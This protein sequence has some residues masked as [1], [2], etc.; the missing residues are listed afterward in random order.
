MSLSETPSGG[1]AHGA[2]PPSHAEPV[3][4][5]GG[6]PANDEID[7]RT[8]VRVLREEWVLIAGVFA[9]IVLLA[10]LYTFTRE[11]VYE[12][13]SVVLVDTQRGG[14]RLAQGGIED[15]L[16]LSGGN[17]TLENEVAVL[18]QSVPLA[19]RVAGRLLD[20]GRQ[21]PLT[22]A[23]DEGPPPAVGRVARTMLKD[24]VRFGPISDRADLIRVVASST[25]PE[26]AALLA[27][28]YAEEYTRRSQ[29]SSRASVASS[30]IFLEDQERKR[31]EELDEAEGQ[32]QQFMTREGAVAL[33]SEGQRAV[34]QLAQLDS[35]I[36][37]AQVELE[38][39][40]TALRS[41]EA[42]VERIQPGLSRRLASG[43]EAEMRRV[44]EQIAELEI[45]ASDYYA[46]NP[47]LRG[48][49][50]ANAELLALS[51]RITGLRQRLDDLS[52]RY[53]QEV[54]AVGGVDGASGT[55]TGL[56]YLTELQ[57][58]AIQRR[59]RIQGLEAKVRALRQQVGQYEVRLRDIPRQ[60]IQLAQLQRQQQAITDTYLFLVQKLQEARVAEE[61][62][63]GY[64][65]IIR[66][67]DVPERPVRPRPLLN[68][69]VA[70]MLGLMGG[71]GAALLRR[72]LDHRVRS[73]EDLREN[74]FSVLGT[75]PD[76]T[77]LI[78][79]HF[80]G[81]EKV[82]IVNREVYA[83][84]AAALHPRSPLTEA[85]RQ[86]RTSVRFSLPDTELK[87]VSVTSTAP[88]E[89]KSTTSLQ[90]ALSMASAG[91]RTLYI[92]G[93][94]RK[95]TGH[96]HLG[97]DRKRGLSELLFQA[98]PVDWE[99]YR[100]RLVADWADFEETVEDLYVITAGKPVPSPSELLGSN[101]MRDLVTEMRREFDFVVIDTPPTLL[102]TD[103]VLAAY[104]S[105][106]VVL[107][108]RAEQTNWDALHRTRETV[109]QAGTP[110]IG[111]VL[112]RFG[113]RA[114]GGY[115]YGYG[116]Y[117][118]G[119]GADFTFALSGD[120]SSRPTVPVPSVESHA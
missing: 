59:I 111:V 97:L 2:R 62:E 95:P 120:G 88:G 99:S 85:A 56:P 15:L 34:T 108:A 46:V 18:Q 29:E 25:D 38:I 1:A 75:F 63:L 52:G 28:L 17:R 78:K 107:V 65:Q 91:L 24:H 54:L 53:L 47:S 41:L 74:G 109:A 44:Q 61:S 33:D 118:Y 58:D 14:A 87:V 57:R 116:S 7:L 71:V 60:S 23:S 6:A 35:Q 13:D 37:E 27:N 73:P 84:I 40:R 48:N 96:L 45:Q 8:L 43:I 102:V 32:L 100:C 110:V 39:E 86:L 5:P 93:D 105:D 98:G 49:E 64:I 3:G 90:L 11:P 104:L 72:A 68:L 92:D 66:R 82:Q 70:V 19:E 113:R 36:E 21:G 94:L 77:A 117:G 31:R 80:G 101:R 112:N 51:T 20:T 9:A 83:T 12:T 79:E 103:A 16:R 50:A 30:R 22:E 76:A 42:E 55:A 114:R 4:L 67:A 115:G 26:E 119:Y 81:Q 10:A 89:G 69:M 106:A